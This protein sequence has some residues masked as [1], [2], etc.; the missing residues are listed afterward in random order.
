MRL[1]GSFVL[2]QDAELRPVLEFA[3]ELRRNAGAQDGDF[4]LSRK[5]SR[6]HSKILDVSAAQLIR[7]FEKPST[8]AAAVARFSR[9]QPNASERLPAEQILEDAMPLLRSLIDQGLLVEAG[10]AQVFSTSESL[11]SGDNVDEW[12]VAR[13]IQSLEDTELY[14]VSKPDGQ[15][16]AL[17]IGRPEED[18]ARRMLEREAELL[19]ENAASSLPRL[20]ATGTWR[21]RLYLVTE[22]FAGVDAESAAIEIRREGDPDSRQQL[23]ALAGSI[24]EAYTDL[25]E[26]GLLHGDIHPRNLL[27]DRNGVVK[28]LDL[29]L[30]AT[31]EKASR[32][33]RGGISF[34]YEPEFARATLADLPAPPATFAGEQYSLAAMLYVLLTGSHTQDF[35][36]ER[37]EMLSQIANGAMAPFAQRGIEAW[38]AVEEVLAKALSRDVSH[39]YPSTRDFLQAWRA[40]A[41]HAIPQTDPPQR[42]PRLRRISREVLSK[43]VPNGEWMREGFKVAATTPIN[44]GSAGLAYALFRIACATDDG[45]LLATADAWSMRAAA[46]AVDSEEAFNIKPTKSSALKVGLASLHH[47]RPGVD[48]TQA[49]I[50]SARGDTMLHDRAVDRFIAWGRES[51]QEPEAAI[52]LTLGFAGSLLASA[53]LLDSLTDSGRSKAASHRKAELLAFGNDLSAKLWTIL[54]GYAPVGEPPG[55]EDTGVAHGWAGILYSSL[56]WNAS[57]AFPM[58]DSLHRRL[59]QLAARAEPIVRGLHWPWGKRSSFPSWC[60]GSAG[61]VFLWTEAHNA[62]GDARYLALAEGAAWNTWET[63]SRFVSLCCGMGGQAYALLNFYRLTGDEIWLRR[64]RKMADWAAELAT[65]AGAQTADA[66]SETRAGSLYN[67]LAGLAV[68]DADLDCPLDARMPLFERD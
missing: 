2:P 8:I 50:A 31:L 68:L 26:H 44:N 67:S 55:L 9:A 20:L 25:H 33:Q 62:T 4:A 12:I 58:T 36:L 5:N 49:L 65:A 15:W 30:A 32:T 39:R 11:A 16:G 19:G 45:E 22:W 52:D 48:A 18:R 10:S 3:E 40:V 6:S 27:V 17:K 35:K 41:S 57:A 13:C 23:H 61:Q 53:F 54:N 1:S 63:P 64:A 34:Y 43:S 24:L 66:P 51:M 37:V 46:A 59:H 47:H 14:V 60:N 28:I 38:P 7:Q 29:G 56:V 21:E 42:D